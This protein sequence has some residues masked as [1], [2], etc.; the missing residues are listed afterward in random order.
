MENVATE[1]VVK[2]G[3]HG[4]PRVECNQSDKLYLKSLLLMIDTPSIVIE[5][6]K[7]IPLILGNSTKVCEILEASTRCGAECAGRKRL[8][9]MSTEIRPTSAPGKS[10]VKLADVNLILHVFVKLRQSIFSASLLL[11]Q[12]CLELHERC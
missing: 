6:S 10:S 2:N 5:G 9:R 3:G 1:G 4:K 11:I 8:Q 12:G 7:R